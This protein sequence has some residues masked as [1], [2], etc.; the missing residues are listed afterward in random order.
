[1]SNFSANCAICQP[2]LAPSC[3]F[4]LGGLMYERI[5]NLREDKDL[6][7]KQIAEHLNCSQRVY[8]NYE[9]GQ[10]DIPTHVLI[11]LAKF[12]E[13][14]TDYLLGISDNPASAKK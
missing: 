7:Q 2:L 10:R 13:T 3:I 9:H 6:T 11:A 1:M 12:H 5:R 4:V 8:S 14:S